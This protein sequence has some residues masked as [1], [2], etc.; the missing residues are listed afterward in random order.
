M[1]AKI[2]SYML[3]DETINDDKQNFMKEVSVSMSNKK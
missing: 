2:S 3:E 1:F